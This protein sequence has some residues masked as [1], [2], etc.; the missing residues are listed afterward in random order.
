MAR[1]RRIISDEQTED[2]FKWGVNAEIEE[3]KLIDMFNEKAYE[4]DEEEN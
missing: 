3:Q 2:I 4:L 1:D